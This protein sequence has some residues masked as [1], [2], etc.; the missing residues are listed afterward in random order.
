MPTGYIMPAP[1]NLVDAGAVLTGYGEYE[2]YVS[3]GVPTT[4]MPAWDLVLN[5]EEIARVIFYIQGFASATD[6]KQNWA[7]LYTDSFARTMKE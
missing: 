7:P 6:Y 2:Y 3:R 4:N 5:K 1:Y